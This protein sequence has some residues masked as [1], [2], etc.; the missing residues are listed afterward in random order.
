M[1]DEKEIVVK[2]PSRPVVAPEKKAQK[3]AER[4][5]EEEKYGIL[6]VSKRLSRFLG[7]TSLASGVL[8]VVLMA[9][10]DF[11]GQTSLFFLS[12][13]PPIP[14]IGLWIFIGLINIVAGF[15]LMGS[16]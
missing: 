12:L 1:S 16:E 11:S 4:A 7:F 13:N 8:L 3:A 6:Q 5:V 10:G 9:Y 2:A 15:L 14:I